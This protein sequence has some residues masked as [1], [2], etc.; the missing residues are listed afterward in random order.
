V[1]RKLLFYISKNGTPLNMCYLRYICIFICVCYVYYIHFSWSTRAVAIII[2]EIKQTNNKIQTA[3]RVI[4]DFEQ[5]LL[6]SRL[7]THN[8]RC[9]FS[10]IQIHSHTQT[11][12][13]RGSVAD[14]RLTGIITRAVGEGTRG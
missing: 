1:A 11:K 4:N 6:Y 12:R 13:S 9:R 8:H 14:H 7:D 3:R 2:I 5:R 10:L